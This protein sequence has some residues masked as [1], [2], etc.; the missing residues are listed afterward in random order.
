M[1][2]ILKTGAKKA[3]STSAFPPSPVTT[4][5]FCIQQIMDTVLDLAFA[6]SVFLETFKKSLTIVA[7][8]SSSWDL[9]F[10]IFS[11]HELVTSL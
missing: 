6:A 9:A 5:T 8:S 11:L 10:L 1:G 3:L 7:K 2:L 4:P